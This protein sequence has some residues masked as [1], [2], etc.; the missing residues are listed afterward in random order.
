MKN[1]L[2]RLFS[3]FLFFI[4]ISA[5]A[6]QAPV[7]RKSSQS[8]TINGKSLAANRIFSLD[9]PMLSKQLANVPKKRTGQ[10]YRNDG[11]FIE[12][13][14]ISGEMETYRVFE[15]PVLSAGLSV[16]FPAIKSFTGVSVNNPQHKIK[17][18]LDAF[19]FHGMLFYGS[20]TYYINPVTKGSAT[21]FLAS[22][23]DFEGKI[24]ACDFDEG[25]VVKSI[26]NDFQ[27]RGE[28]VNDGQLRTYRLAL[29]ST[30][31]Y[32]NFH[33]NAAGVS[34]GTDAQKKAAV[35]SAMNTTMTRV[36][37]VYERDLSI[38]MEIIPN[39][40]LIIFL[41]PATDGLTNNDGG[42]LIDEIQNV[43]DSGVGFSNY[44]IGH[45]F[46][47]G[48][49]G[50]AQLNSPCT[51]N[52]A[53]GVTGL[54]APVGDLFDI[55]F[56]AHEM[57]HQFGATHTFNNSCSNNR[58]SAT[59][60]EPGSGSTI[61]AYAGICPPN[62]QP[63]SD[64]YF[65]AVSIA[66][67]WQNITA[68][69]STCSVNTNSGNNAPVAS[70]G[71]DFAIPR[72]TAFILEAT[73]TDANSDA[74]TYCWEQIDNQ[75]STQAPQPTSTSGPN[76]RSFDP[77]TSPKR[78]FPRVSDILNNNL[79][80]TWEV[81]PSVG[82]TM[83]FS[84]MVRDNNPA[85]GQTS[86]DD[87]RI[88]VDG[89]TGPFRVTSQN[90]ASTL[91]AGDVIAVTWDVANT[92]LAPVNTQEVDIYMVLDNDFENL[93][94]LTQNTPNDGSQNVVVPGGIASSNVRIMVKPVNNIYF[95]V[96]TATLSLVESEFVLNFDSLETEACKPNNAIYN[97]VYNS[98]NSFAG[99]VTLSTNSVPAGLT[100]AFSPTS[101]SA[102]NTNV[103]VTVSGV[104]SLDNGAY[105]FNVVATSGS[106]NKTYPLSLL[107]SDD[108]FQVLTLT[109]P[110]NGATNLGLNTLFSWSPDANA[111]SYVIEI[112]QDNSFATIDET[113]VTPTNSYNT[114]ALNSS[115]TYFWRVKPQNGCGEGAFST[116][117]S[118]STIDISCDTFV[119]NTSVPIS[120]QGTPT[121]TSTIN[122]PVEGSLFDVTVNLNI[123]HTW[124]SD[125]T[126][127]LTSPSGTVVPLLTQIC[128]DAS[129]I[130]ATFSD[131]GTDVTCG[132]NPAVSGTVKPNSP[133][134]V[135]KD[136][137]VKGNWI[138]T[139][140]DGAA[141]DGGAI[142]SF[143][144]NICVNGNFLTDTD[145][146][147][148]FDT[149]DV[150]PN[151]PAGTK[152]DVT[153][154]PLFSLPNDN[155]TIRTLSETCRD[156]NNG[157]LTI[158]A[159]DQNFNYTANLTGASTGNS[160]F[161]STTAFTN[162][163][164]GNYRVC[165][166]VDGQPDYEQCFDFT[167]TEPDPLQVRAELNKG[168]NTLVLEMTGGSL[169]NVEINGLTTQTAENTIELTLKPGA[170]FVKVTTGKDCQGVFE[171]VFVS[172]NGTEVFPNPFSSQLT[173]LTGIEARPVTISLY[174]VLG[175]KIME[176]PFTTSSSGE[177]TV[178][179]DSL[180]PGV[181]F[182]LINSPEIRSTK[183]IIKL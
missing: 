69:N 157:S 80:P 178:N 46:S 72:G 172:G 7:W 119:N 111:D 32:S 24:F 179:T 137:P 152:V 30:G 21:F 89:N 17:F 28:T 25:D 39:N 102:N 50:I 114:T 125:L 162:L 151:T 99:T 110:A 156:N 88:T 153:G 120:A 66:Q 158:T 159:Q 29:A 62:V 174:T 1:T 51:S 34:T 33:I 123:S 49:G 56:V 19:G 173:V 64:D 3:A 60:V 107:V 12:F 93:V 138:L 90:A 113:A 65:H 127:T 37:G 150:C 94:A 61:M 116:V 177:I 106:I 131:A 75:I 57:G 160:S 181:Y 74:L 77:S 166:T 105:T 6:Q 48:G 101:V 147:G 68:G 83:N 27:T 112:S 47:T 126:I 144:L 133:F 97:L 122:V 40:D 43:I 139:V 129:N 164:A 175:E 41:D 5:Q 141:Q 148:V 180:S 92:N 135:L 100:V 95:A 45:V 63:N 103:Q 8:K 182:I 15:T 35:L 20:K 87:M 165:I 104:G 54:S 2:L 108:T 38:T 18:T 136:E 145:G 176:K 146:D 70:A 134:S 169:Y 52:K 118:F 154:C 76:F 31:E 140:A 67:I 167:V 11:T 9:A 85:G 124:V 161:T 79:T 128:D 78:F 55:D 130:V 71:N 82:R 91:T 86:R 98:F 142:N 143:G 22:K 44:D 183:K 168:S 13:P 53:R 171:R 170:N 14:S 117:F 42:T 109:S 58:S 149:D 115:T 4:L 96:N 132:A 23:S 10:S 84:V 59:A 155:F 36:N 121:V 73:A 81:I 26:K 16:K 163:S